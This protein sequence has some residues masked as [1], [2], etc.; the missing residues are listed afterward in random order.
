VH[1]ENINVT[2]ALLDSANIKD[3]LTGTAE[4]DAKLLINGAAKNSEEQMRGIKGDVDFVITKGQFGPFGKIENLI[5]AENIRE[6]QF[7][8]T[9]L[10]GIINKLT[11]IDTTHF[12]ELKGHLTFEDGICHINPITSY[13]DILSLHV[14]GDFDLIKNYAD[15]KVRARMAS[16]ISK[17]LGPLNA[18][19]PVNIMNSAASLNVVTAKAFSLF[20]EVVPSKELETLPSF[21]NKYVDS[22]AAKFQ[23]GVRGDAAK[24]LTLV[25]S[26]KWLSSRTEYDDAMDY[27]NSLPEEIEGSTATNI[28]EAI[29]EAKALEAEKKTLKYKVKHIFKRE[30]VNEGVN[31][32]VKLEGPIQEEVEVLPEEDM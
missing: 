17:L 5:I 29:A 19:N 24:P 7:F 16:L 32:K 23:L 26:F 6:S 20:C 14:F 18:I 10:G 8:Q 28:E 22:G 9:A 13:G 3:M 11:S 1:G 2:R 4:F 12:E 15:M 30:G 21:A 31:K 27:V 25:K